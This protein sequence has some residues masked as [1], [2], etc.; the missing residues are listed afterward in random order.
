[1]ELKLLRGRCCIGVRPVDRIDRARQHTSGVWK[2]RHPS[3]D[4]VRFG[5]LE[6]ALGRAQQEK[7]HG[8][9]DSLNIV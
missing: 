9:L 4:P 1:M 7:V 8:E 2:R 3:V 6:R 5:W